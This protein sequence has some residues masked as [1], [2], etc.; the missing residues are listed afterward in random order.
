MR[1]SSMPYC[2]HYAQHPRIEYYWSR[3]HA[4]HKHKHYHS[5]FIGFHSSSH[6][7]C[8]IHHP[9]SSEIHGVGQAAIRKGS[10]VTYLR[11]YRHDSGS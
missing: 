6:N 7:N 1:I 5:E 3:Q 8:G 4:V 2:D 10:D 11:L 9:I